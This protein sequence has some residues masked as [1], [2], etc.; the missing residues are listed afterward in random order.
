MRHSIEKL[1]FFPALRK[2]QQDPEKRHVLIARLLRSHRKIQHDESRHAENNR[3][4]AHGSEV[5]QFARL[6][7]SGNA[8][9]S[10]VVVP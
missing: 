6:P 5:R 10:L 4:H 3:R 8:D 7:R 2:P 1:T 9:R